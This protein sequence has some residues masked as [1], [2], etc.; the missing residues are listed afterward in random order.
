M[1]RKESQAPAV[2]CDVELSNPGAAWCIIQ[3]GTPWI[4]TSTYLTLT[5]G[6][7]VVTVQLPL[8][9]VGQQAL[10]FTLTELPGSVPAGNISNEPASCKY[11][12]QTV[13]TPNAPSATKYLDAQTA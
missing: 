13:D 12:L 11:R 1:M 2:P 3:P 4:N 8:T 9:P 7:S 6:Q 10:K 5:G